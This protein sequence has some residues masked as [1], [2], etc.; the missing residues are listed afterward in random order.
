MLCFNCDLNIASY[1]CLDCAPGESALCESCK[2]I[3][4]KVKIF[5]KHKVRKCPVNI[6]SSHPK[7]EEI[8]MTVD[9]IEPKSIVIF[10][11]EAFDWLVAKTAAIHCCFHDFDLLDESTFDISE[12]FTLRTCVACVGVA[13]LIHAVM[14]YVLGRR[15]VFAVL[16]VGIWMFRTMKRKR[17]AYLSEIDALQQ[18]IS[19]FMLPSLAFQCSNNSF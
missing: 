3:H 11:S 9:E 19:L 7:Y 2:L 14:K 5:A 15:A 13:F 8:V 4:G 16:G 6:L 17:A 10:F 18:V 1:K 12:G